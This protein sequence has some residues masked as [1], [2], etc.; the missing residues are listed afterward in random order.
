MRK[1]ILIL[2]AT[3]AFSAFAD[4][5]SFEKHMK[6]DYS[7]YPDYRDILT[8]ISYRQSLFRVQQRKESAKFRAENSDELKIVEFNHQ[9]DLIRNKMASEMDKV[10]EDYLKEQKRARAVAS[11]SDAR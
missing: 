2:I 3:M 5:E 4:S 6:F 1:I 11:E 8:E 9:Q 10:A 7:K